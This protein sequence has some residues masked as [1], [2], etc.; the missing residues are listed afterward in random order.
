MFGW[1]AFPLVILAAMATIIAS[2]ALI[3]GAFSLTRQA[4][5]MRLLPRMQIR[6]T[7]GRHQGQIYIGA[8]NWTLMAGAILVVIGFRTSSNLGAAYG[9][10]VSGTMLV[11]VCS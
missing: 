3:S 4:M 11:T 8:I 1:A 7:S 2:Q 9:I 5:Q 6:S 10:A